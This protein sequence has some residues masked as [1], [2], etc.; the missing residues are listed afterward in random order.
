MFF[1]MNLI[2]CRGLL[3]AKQLRRKVKLLDPAHESHTC[4]PVEY[5]WEKTE[6]PPPPCKAYV[7]LVQDLMFSH[8]PLSFVLR[9]LSYDVCFSQLFTEWQFKVYGQAG[10]QDP[11]PTGFSC[12]HS[13]PPNPLSTMILS[14]KVTGELRGTPPQIQKQG[15]DCAISY[16]AHRQSVSTKTD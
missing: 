10:K 11:T 4:F 1:E 8:S 5:F 6:D 16:K 12:C 14:Q 13:P 9:L 2:C 7:C 3:S 15:L